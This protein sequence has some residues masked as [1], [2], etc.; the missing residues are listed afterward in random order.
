MCFRLLFSFLLSVIFAQHVFANDID[1]KLLNQCGISNEDINDGVTDIQSVSELLSVMA[2]GA[3][4][5]SIIFIDQK[6]TSCLGCMNIKF[7]KFMYQ[8]F[9]RKDNV[10][11]ATVS[12]LKTNGET[13]TSYT[14]RTPFQFI[15]TSQ[16][17]MLANLMVH[18]KRQRLQDNQLIETYP[19]VREEN[20]DCPK[21][22][23]QNM[24][25]YCEKTNSGFKE[26]Q[27]ERLFT[28]H[29]FPNLLFMDGEKINKPAL[30]Q[31]CEAHN[32]QPIIL[33]ENKTTASYFVN[34]N[35]TL[36]SSVLSNDKAMLLQLL[37]YNLYKTGSETAE[38]LEVD[39]TINTLTQLLN[40]YDSAQ[41]DK[42]D[43]SK[44]TTTIRQGYENTA[45]LRK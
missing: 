34:G 42:N 30:L 10:V 3:I 45:S 23:N 1:D 39:G 33:S 4:E 5:N 32:Q 8:N 19:L 24:N 17:Y 16:A 27:S 11:A 2:Q 28:R 9:R 12:Y 22:Q 31:L 6:Y 13:Q 36:I 43:M 40:W 37:N 25:D 20:R 35:E 29:H 41:L 7:G 15:E 21:S 14:K 38:D 18:N 26:V 44:I